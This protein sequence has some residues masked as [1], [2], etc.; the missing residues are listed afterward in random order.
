MRGTEL[1]VALLAPAHLTV[2]I[3][4][5]YR[6]LVK[7]VQKPVKAVQKPA[8]AAQKRLADMRSNPKSV[9][10]LDALAVAESCFGK[11]RVDG[12]HHV[13]KTPWPG[14]PR[15]NLQKAKGGGAKPY[16]VRQL[17]AAI[18]KLTALEAGKAE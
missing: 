7:A 4:I 11:P 2:S 6:T 5:P 8:K 18:D 13:F 9:R 1:H 10:F 12:S 16:Q 15:I 17:L 3:V 14:D